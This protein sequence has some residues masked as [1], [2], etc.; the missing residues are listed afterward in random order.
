VI[1]IRSFWT[2]KEAGYIAC[3]PFITTAKIS[4]TPGCPIPAMLDQSANCSSDDTQTDIAI[5]SID[6]KLCAKSS[7][8]FN[9]R[10][11]FAMHPP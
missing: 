7:S 3:H 4:L 2:N 11:K 5:V 6:V 8:I 9:R 1:T 10:R